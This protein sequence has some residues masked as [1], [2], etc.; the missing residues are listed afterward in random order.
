M[1]K[2][3]LLIVEDHALIR[4]GLMTA[5]E[6]KDFVGEIFEAPNAEDAIEIVKNQ[7]VD[8]VIMDIGLPNTDGIQASA[9]IKEINP[10]IKILILTSHNTQEEVLSSIKAGA[11][12]YCSKEINPDNLAIVVKSVLDGAI[13]FDSNVAQV[14]LDAA[15]KDSEKQKSSVN[16]DYN[17]TIRE[18]QVLKLI[19][20]G[21]NNNEIAKKL[22]VSVNT[23]KVHVSSII[24]KLGVED[25]TQA[26]IKALN[27]NII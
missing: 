6:S 22:Y 10:E 5:F 15:S 12:A 24:Q 17:L 2:H 27:D 9:K 16:N 25:R 3:N 21:Y 11:S 18:K 1:Q 20:E 23:A 4:F 7:S 19:R 26:A 14:V 8:A 13:W